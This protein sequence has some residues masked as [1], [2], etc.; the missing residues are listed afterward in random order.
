MS[1]YFSGRCISGK[2]DGILVLPQPADNFPCYWQQT[3]RIMLFENTLCIACALYFQGDWSLVQ[4]AFGQ[5]EIVQIFWLEKSQLS[6]CGQCLGSLL[7]FGKSLIPNFW[8]I[9]MQYCDIPAACYRTQVKMIVEYLSP[10]E[11]R[12]LL[13]SLQT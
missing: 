11:G 12:R 3:S 5:R 4:R 1:S 7:L 6:S 2:L 10:S 13:T 8:C 9:E